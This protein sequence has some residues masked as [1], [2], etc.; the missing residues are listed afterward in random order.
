MIQPA[1]IDVVN[2]LKWLNG[3]MQGQHKI[4]RSFTGL[5]KT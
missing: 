3:F 5:S 2:R 1:K 4:K